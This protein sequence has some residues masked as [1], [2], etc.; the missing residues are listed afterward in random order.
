[1][2][3]SQEQLKIFE[4]E[5]NTIKHPDSI[6]WRTL[7]FLMALWSFWLAAK[8]FGVWFTL[9]N[10][11]SARI[12]NQLWFVF[13][14]FAFCPLLLLS[15]YFRTVLGMILLCLGFSFSLLTLWGRPF[16]LS[17]SQ[18]LIQVLE[19]GIPMIVAGSMQLFRSRMTNKDRQQ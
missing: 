9:N 19:I 13:G 1:M 7:F 8:D 2:T 3:A 4:E 6:A 15:F 16:S 10:D 12:A 17:A 11:E 18:A 5:T 14:P